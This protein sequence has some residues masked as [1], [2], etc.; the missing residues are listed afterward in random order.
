MHWLA[1][2]GVKEITLKV[3]E[4]HRTET[5]I[6]EGSYSVVRHPQCLGGLF[7]HVGIS[8]S[9]S[10]WFSLLF[11]PV[12]VALIYLLSRKEEEELIREFGKEYEDY[13]KRVPML[14]PRLR[15]RRKQVSWTNPF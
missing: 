11:T 8:F 3:A 1:A 9:L 12:M 14:M 10:A 5:I 4:T 7:A 6:T 2:K 15:S 13:K